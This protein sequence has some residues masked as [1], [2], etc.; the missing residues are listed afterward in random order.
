MNEDNQPSGFDRLFPWLL[1]GL[2]ALVIG[3]F[4]LHDLLLS[5]GVRSKLP[6]ACRPAVVHETDAS[7]KSST[8]IGCAPDQ[9]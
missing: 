8:H 4:V 7:G 1:G 2:V 9:P 6:G 3:F 5:H